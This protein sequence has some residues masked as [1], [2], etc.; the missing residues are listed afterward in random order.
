MEDET[1]ERRIAGRGEMEDEI[2]EGV[3]QDEIGKRRIAGRGKMEDETG[4]RRIAGR[5]KIEDQTGK[6][7]LQDEIGKKTYC[8]TW[9]DGGRDWGNAKNDSEKMAEVM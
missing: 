5:G 4:K 2:G 7:V 8:R 9:K 3:L 6:G 1:G